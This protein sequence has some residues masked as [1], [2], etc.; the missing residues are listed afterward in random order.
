MK[1]EKEVKIKILF[2]ILLIII[3]TGCHYN[4]EQLES[5]MNDKALSYYEEHLK[6][7]IVGV[8]Q[9][10]ITLKDLDNQNYNI[11]KFIKQECELDSYVLI[12]FMPDEDND[13]YEIETHLTC[14][15]Y[16]SK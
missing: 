3:V 7:Y 5:E 14:K 1:E 15:N 8:N 2:I 4:Y 16:Q 10:K 9:H 12:K 6:G 13:D 11:N